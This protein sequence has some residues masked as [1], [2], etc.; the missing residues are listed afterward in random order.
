MPARRS[1]PPLGDI[2]ECS[3]QGSLFHLDS[4]HQGFFQ[5][6]RHVITA[7]PMYLARCVLPQL[8][9]PV[10]QQLDRGHRPHLILDIVAPDPN[11]DASVFDDNAG[12][13][14]L[15]L[16]QAPQARGGLGLLSTAGAAEEAYVASLALVANL[17]HEGK[18]L[19]DNFDPEQQG[20]TALPHFEAAPERLRDFVPPPKP[21]VL[22]PMAAPPNTPGAAQPRPQTFFTSTF[23]PASCT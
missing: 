1:A 9:K 17:I 18:L 15:T 12:R 6:I 19:G 22:P 11:R 3:R 7:I 21:I 8:F 5:I 14:L 10:F 16:I 20:A 4:V 2:R 13:R 23:R